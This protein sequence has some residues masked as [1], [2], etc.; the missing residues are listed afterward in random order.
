VP[1]AESEEPVP[2][3]EVPAAADE[4]FPVPSVK[5]AG[6]VPAADAVVVA[7]SLS[8][9]AIEN[10]EGVTNVIKKRKRPRILRFII[11]PTMEIISTRFM[12]YT[13]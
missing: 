9:C 4:K 5:L 13:D 8:L 6:S 11:P 1:E 2:V 3:V 12:P 10:E 7:F